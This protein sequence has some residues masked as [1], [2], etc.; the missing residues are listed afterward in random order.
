MLS[1]VFQCR[2]A[3]FNDD[4][5]DLISFHLSQLFNRAAGPSNCD[6]ANV[7]S[8]ASRAMRSTELRVEKAELNDAAR[9]FLEEARQGR[10]ASS[11][12]AR[13]ALGRGAF[14]RSAE[15]DGLGDAQIRRDRAGAAPVVAGIA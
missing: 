10:S 11:P 15:F 8:F 14:T 3:R 4:P 9:E 1:P 13:T 7:V 2:M 5:D 12:T 6:L